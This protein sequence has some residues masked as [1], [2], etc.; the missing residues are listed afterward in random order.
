MTVGLFDTPE[1][2]AMHGFPRA[3]C[4]PVASR[5]E[6]DDAFVLLDTGPQGQPYLYGVCCSRHDGRWRDG[7]NA[8]GPG[9]SQAGP[10]ITFG[11]LAVWGLAPEGADAMRFE[12]EGT[13]T[14]VPI[15]GIAFLA[16]WWRVPCPEFARP[17]LAGVRIGGR[18]TRE[19]R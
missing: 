9:W 5:V 14:E 16:A 19:T 1:D 11:T 8:N 10:D 7:G 6:G 13:I 15:T 3:H 4:R 2:A 18:W 12:F 17:T